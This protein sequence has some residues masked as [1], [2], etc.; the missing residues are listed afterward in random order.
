MCIRDRI[1]HTE[2]ERNLI[3]KI[4]ETA[5]SVDGVVSVFAIRKLSTSSNQGSEVRV[6]NIIRN[7]CRSDPEKFLNHP[8]IRSMR[9]AKC[10]AIVFVDDFIGSGDRAREFLNGFWLK[11]TITSWLSLKYIEFHV[12]AYS[13]TE[14]GINRVSKHKSKPCLLYTSPSPRDRTRSRMPS[15]A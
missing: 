5:S 7:I 6:A 4:R 15:S 8:E 1:S 13:G 10:R 11:P 14:D 12:V 3:D 9:E 2:F